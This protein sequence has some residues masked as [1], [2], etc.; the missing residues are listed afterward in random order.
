MAG[1]LRGGSH[2]DDIEGNR[3]VSTLIGSI[4]ARN[5]WCRPSPEHFVMRPCLGVDEIKGNGLFANKAMEPGDLLFEEDP[6]LG[7]AIL[8]FG[9]THSAQHCFHCMLKLSSPTEDASETAE[10]AA[11]AK[12]GD[13]THCPRGCGAVFC[14]ETC[15]DD[16][17]WAH[18]EVLCAAS[19]PAWAAFEVHA[20]E[21]ANE[22]Y[23]LAARA[24]A[25]LRHVDIDASSPAARPVAAAAALVIAATSVLDADPLDVAAS[26]MQGLPALGARGDDDVEDGRGRNLGDNAAVSSEPVRQDSWSKLP[27]ASYAGRPWWET[28]RRPKY[29]GSSSGS[30]S[31]RSSSSGS[32]S[33]K[34][35]GSRC[36]SRNSRS[37][38]RRQRESKCKTARL[39]GSRSVGGPSDCDTD[40]AAGNVSAS[41]RSADED[42]TETSSSIGSTDMA[43]LNV[44][45]D[46]FFVEKVRQQTEETSHLM[47]QALFNLPASSPTEPST[48]VNVM[49]DIATDESA[50]GR[51]GLALALETPPQPVSIRVGMEE[52][53]QF[54]QDP[55][56][57]GRLVGLLRTNVLSVQALPSMLSQRTRSKKVGKREQF[58]RGMAMY[59]LTSAMNH[60][61]QPNCI[62]I[63]DPSS[64]QRCGVLACRPVA[65]GDELCI[66]YLEGA[67][68]DVEERLNILEVQYGIPAKALVVTA[69]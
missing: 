49:K 48:L 2:R 53:Q 13:V 28:M 60:H 10:A 16:A 3:P 21:C 27:W 69:S 45:L 54:L 37:S 24:L 38:S 67:P 32:R 65:L 47:L 55:D 4:R 62:A 1:V 8:M 17:W 56:N 7:T 29:G 19:N 39:C 9:E 11:V 26:N 66:N 58:A 64:P 12:T 14:S 61:D 42:S 18:H 34:S 41:S 59:A 46:E 35:D 44:S 36:R 23:V 51:E 30:S 15:R 43:E 5:A 52:V 63:S 31:S 50:V 33:S 25:M 40:S 6:V 22:Y 57:L 20:R 68:Y